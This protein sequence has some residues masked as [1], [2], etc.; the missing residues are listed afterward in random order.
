MDLLRPGFSEDIVFIFPVLLEVLSLLLELRKA[1]YLIFFC[2]L[3]IPASWEVVESFIS[4]PTAS[5]LPPAP[6]LS[7]FTEFL[8]V[9]TVFLKTDLVLEEVEEN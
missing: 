8:L 3:R 1:T 4:L 7:L 9:A 6:S 5:L 2:F